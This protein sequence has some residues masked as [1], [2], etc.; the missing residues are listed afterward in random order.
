MPCAPRTHYHN[1]PYPLS[2][3]RLRI[4]LLC[5]LERAGLGTRGQRVWKEY[6]VC[7]PVED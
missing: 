1:I 2:T 5:N 3:Q 7:R 4:R 6:R